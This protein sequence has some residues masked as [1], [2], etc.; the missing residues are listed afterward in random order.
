LF[1]ALVGLVCNIFRLYN[2]TLDTPCEKFK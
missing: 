1:V 2:L